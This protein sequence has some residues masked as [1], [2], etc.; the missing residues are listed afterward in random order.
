MVDNLKILHKAKYT[1]VRDKK[2]I[3]I[4]S[5]EIVKDD[6]IIIKSGEQIPADAIIIDNSYLEVN[7]SILTG[8]SE[9]IQKIKDDKLLGGSTVISGSAIIQITNVGINSYAG[10]L[11]KLSKQFKL[12]PSEIRKSIN[13]LLIYLGIIIIPVIIALL[14]N[15]IHELTNVPLTQIF[16]NDQGRIAVAHAVGGVIGMIPEGLVLLVSINFAISSIIL[17]KKKILVQEL[18]SVETLARINVL[19]IDKTGTITDGKIKLENIKYYANKLLVNKALSTIAKDKSANKSVSIFKNLSKQSLN[20]K[21]TLAFSSKKKFSAFLIGKNIWVL[22]MPEKFDRKSAGYK[23]ASSKTKNG[24]RVLAVGLIKTSSIAN[25]NKRFND[26]EKHLPILEPIAIAVLDENIRKNAK[27]IIKYFREQ[28][29]DVQIISGDNL[30]T[31]ITIAKKIGL[32]IKGA[33]DMSAYNS[34]MI[35]EKRIDNINVFARVT[36]EQKQEIILYLKESNNVVAMTG[37]GVNDILALKKSDLAIAMADAVPAVKNASQLILSDNAFTF[38]PKVVL[39]GRRILANIERT[40]TLFLIKTSFTL[41]SIILICILDFTY[42][43]LPRQLTL[44]GMWTIGIP[45]FF[46]SILPNSKRYKKGFIKRVLKI[47]VPIG[48]SNGIIAFAIYSVSPLTFKS[49]NATLTL[50]FLGLFV[51]YKCIQPLNMVR[52]ALF[53]S[54]CLGAILSIIFFNNIFLLT[55]PT[56]DYLFLIISSVIFGAA[57]IQLFITSLSNKADNSA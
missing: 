42:P 48:I 4:Y 16:Q 35:V 56:A 17:A 55:F 23:Y 29:I 47:A 11:T 21:K 40:S 25:A 1:C 34:N 51:L 33:I 20:I 12:A 50:L 54:M 28:N 8:E 46:M 3:Q 45:G 14:Y 37:D 19:C 31:V 15:E 49:T 27:T 26:L 52:C 24:K 5:D 7:E 43:Y 22:G 57:F 18:A 32:K 44:I 39:E 41:V 30:D 36:P 53:I 13:K 9:N 38:L 2:E 6:I 10:R